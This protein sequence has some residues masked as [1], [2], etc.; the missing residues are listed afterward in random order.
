MADGT[1]G[2]QI[3]EVSDPAHPQ[4]VGGFNSG[5]AAIRVTVRGDYLYLGGSSGLEILD[6]SDPAGPA[7]RASGF[8]GAAAYRTEFAGDIAYVATTGGLEVFDIEDP[9]RPVRLGGNLAF[10]CYDIVL[11][12]GVLY[13]AAWGEGIQVLH[14]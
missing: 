3:V 8:S 7:L 2:L 11:G 4:K 14:E 9:A 5:N 10:M 12:D 13:S 1:N 6:I